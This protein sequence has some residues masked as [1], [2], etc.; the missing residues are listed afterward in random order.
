M[1]GTPAD[2]ISLTAA[3]AGRRIAAFLNAV[4]SLPSG[5]CSATAW[6]ALT[7]LQ[8]SLPH[9]VALR[10]YLA[11]WRLSMC[12]EML[13]LFDEDRIEEARQLQR[14]E[15]AARAKPA[16][17]LQAPDGTQRSQSLPPGPRTTAHLA[18]PEPAVRLG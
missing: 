2:T 3:A 7:A 6:S 10:P 14:A 4:P 11:T 12:I 5:L 9:D 17:G 1:V 16:G 15:D 13:A 8:T 18:S